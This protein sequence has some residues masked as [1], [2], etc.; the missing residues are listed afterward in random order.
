MDSGFVQAWED[1]GDEA[2]Q[3]RLGGV[4]R[5]DDLADVG[6]LKGVGEA[7]VGDDGEGHVSFRDIKHYKRRKR[8]LS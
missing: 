2:G 5:G 7:A 6:R 4:G 3:D 8:W 1:G